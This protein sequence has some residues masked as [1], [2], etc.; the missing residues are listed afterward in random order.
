MKAI[1]ELIALKS[2]AAI[3]LRRRTIKGRLAIVKMLK[4]VVRLSEYMRKSV[5]QL[6]LHD[7]LNE[8]RTIPP[9]VAQECMSLRNGICI[10][11]QEEVGWVL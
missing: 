6:E 5:G 8:L 2:G 11:E 1:G 10:F 4:D 7:K 9:I 3:V